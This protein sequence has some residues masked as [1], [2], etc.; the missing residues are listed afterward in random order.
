MNGEMERST[1]DVAKLVQAVNSKDYASAKAWIGRNKDHL[2]IRQ[3]S[4][5]DN[6]NCVRS[7]IGKLLRAAA[8]GGQVDDVEYFRSYG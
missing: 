1:A 5:E 8:F 6:R 3:D 2:A 7:Q 4:S